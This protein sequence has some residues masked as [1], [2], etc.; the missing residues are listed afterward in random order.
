M[1]WRNPGQKNC[2]FLLTN[3]SD[4]IIIKSDVFIQ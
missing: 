4:S 1:E 2:N 3:G